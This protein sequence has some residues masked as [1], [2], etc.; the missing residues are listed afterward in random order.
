MQLFIVAHLHHYKWQTIVYFQLRI[1]ADSTF[2]YA[3]YQI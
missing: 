3:S 2:I 1:M